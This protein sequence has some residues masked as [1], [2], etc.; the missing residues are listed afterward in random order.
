MGDDDITQKVYDFGPISIKAGDIISSVTRKLRY[1]RPHMSLEER[2]K[3]AIQ[4][5][6]NSRLDARGNSAL[7][8]GIV[9]LILKEINK[10]ISK[11]ATNL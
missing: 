1:D 9:A 8:D 3:Y 4:T 6:E 11:R 10:S 2:R 7:Y 5:L